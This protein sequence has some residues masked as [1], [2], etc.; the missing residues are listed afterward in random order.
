M[1]LTKDN[2]FIN[3]KVSYNKEIY[4]IVKINAKTV[5]LAKNENFLSEW[6][7]RQKGIKWKDFCKGHNAFMVAYGEIEIDEKEAKKKESIEAKNEIMKKH[8]I[9]MGPIFEKEAREMWKRYLKKQKNPDKGKAWKYPIE[10]SKDVLYPIDIS[11]EKEVMLLKMNETFFFYFVNDGV[12]LPFNKED[13]KKGKN[14]LWPDSPLDKIK[15]E[16]S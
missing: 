9:S 1:K 8:L 11:K 12:Y 7:T 16:A 6:K 5:Y 4:Y 10:S 2:A 3:A 15:A 14:I 13:H